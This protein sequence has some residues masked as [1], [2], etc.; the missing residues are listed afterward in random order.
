V[1]RV[2]DLVEQLTGQR[3]LDRVGEA[4]EVLVEGLD[5]DEGHPVG[6]AAH[7]G[8]DVDGVTLLPREHVAADVGPL[9]VGDVV[10]AR[11]VG[12]HGVDLVAAAE[13]LVLPAAGRAG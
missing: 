13:E 3:A 5:E 12:A 8:P 2:G 1:A 7:Q 9:A 4:V 10:R 6:R 11:V